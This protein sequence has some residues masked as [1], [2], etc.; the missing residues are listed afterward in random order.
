MKCLLIKQFVDDSDSAFGSRLNEQSFMKTFECKGVFLWKIK[1]MGIC[2]KM[3]TIF[4]EDIPFFPRL[5][6]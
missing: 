1:N 2:D 4:T 6:T 3:H 5:L